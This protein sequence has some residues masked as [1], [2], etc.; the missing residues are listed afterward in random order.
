MHTNAYKGQGGSKHDHN[1][2]FV[3]RFI[4]NTTIF[5]TFKDRQQLSAPTSL[6]SCKFYDHLY[7]L[8][9]RMFSY[10]HTYL[11]I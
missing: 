9:L 5:D 10:Y 7:Y 8:L 11:M 3:R 2:H 4:E 6:C 1:T